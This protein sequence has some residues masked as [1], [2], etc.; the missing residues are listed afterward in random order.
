MFGPA[1]P[2][3]A[4]LISLHIYIN[5]FVNWNFGLGAAMSVMLLL[6]LIIVS[7]IY[8]RALRVGSQINE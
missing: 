8:V 4:E 7:A 6:F 3:S 5:S 2:S 1:P